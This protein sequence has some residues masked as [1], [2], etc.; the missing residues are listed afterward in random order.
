MSSVVKSKVLV[1]ICLMMSIVCAAH[2][3]SVLVAACVIAL[4][5]ASVAVVIVPNLDCLLAS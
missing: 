4:F 5:R 3:G 2:V 1:A